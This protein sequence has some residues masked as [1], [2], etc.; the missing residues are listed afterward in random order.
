[1]PDC[2]LAASKSST[3]EYVFTDAGAARIGLELSHRFA[4][5]V[6]FPHVVLDNFLPESFAAAILESFP[7]VEKASV[8]RLG[9]HQHFKRGYRPDDLGDSPARFHAHAFNTRPVLLFLEALTG[10]TGLIADPGYAGG[11]YHEIARGGW[12]DVHA[13]FQRHPTLGLRRR[14]NLVLYLN[15]DWLPAYGGNIELWSGDATRPVVSVAPLFNRCVIFET[16]ATSFHG[17]PVPLACPDDRTRRSL[18]VYYYTV[19]APGEPPGSLRPD[20]DWRPA[21][22]RAGLGSR[23]R[24]RLRALWSRR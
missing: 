10:I 19:P 12:L 1:M 3:G 13:D 7:P 15:R 11:G 17:H 24:S 23:L 22:R 4:G 6:P 20:T 8:S 5:A 14:V 16:G 21:G 18:A 9:T 2:V